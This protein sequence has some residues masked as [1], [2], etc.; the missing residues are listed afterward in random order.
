M[1]VSALMHLVIFSM[2]DYV[3]MRNC[4]LLKMGKKTYKP[5]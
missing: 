3:Q 4:I 2:H 5:V 1:E